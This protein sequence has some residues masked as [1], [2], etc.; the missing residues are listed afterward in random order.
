MVDLW[1]LGEFSQKG[2]TRTKWG[3]FEELRNLAAIA[4]DKNMNLY[5]DAVLNHKAGADDTEKCM[6][7]VCD[8]NGAS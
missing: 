8:Q 2:T 3:T 5:F 1:D 6:A 7:I 4:K